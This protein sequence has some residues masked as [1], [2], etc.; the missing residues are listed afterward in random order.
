VGARKLASL[1]KKK[2]TVNDLKYVE[3]TNAAR[4]L[5][6]KQ[7]II[8]RLTWME[9]ERNEGGHCASTLTIQ[10]L[11]CC[12]SAGRAQTAK[13]HSQDD[14]VVEECGNCVKPSE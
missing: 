14:K 8:H 7:T 11:S 6:F 9:L 12:S 1:N 4:H 2:Q 13:K 5:A 3:Q 10:T